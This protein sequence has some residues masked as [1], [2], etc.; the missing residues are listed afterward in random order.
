[1]NLDEIVSLLDRGADLVEEFKAAGWRH[2]RSGSTLTSD[3]FT[4]D[5]NAVTITRHYNRPEISIVLTYADGNRTT[6][7][8]KP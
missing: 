1:M 3:R 7:E 8:W 5:E 2:D 4:R 6:N